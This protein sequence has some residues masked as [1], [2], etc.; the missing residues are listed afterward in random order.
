MNGSIQIVDLLVKEVLVDINSKN[1]NG[2][3]PLGSAV[4]VGNDTI[5]TELIELG[6]DINIQDKNGN[7]P[8]HF[9]SQLG[10]T[11][12]IKLL[13]KNNVSI[14]TKNSNDQTPKDV[15]CNEQTKLLFE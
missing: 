7:T 9:A 13:I 8:L 4:I 15:A 1:I 12:I 6:C 11:S 14:D 3:T 5:V 2:V 10:Y